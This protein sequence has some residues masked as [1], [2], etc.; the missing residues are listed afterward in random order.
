MS[1]PAISFADLSN[2]FM[3]TGHIIHET[4]LNL[5]TFVDKKSNTFAVFDLKHNLCTVYNRPGRA[6]QFATKDFDYA[7]D[8]YKP[9]VY[10]IKELNDCNNSMEPD[11]RLEEKGHTHPN[12]YQIPALEGLTNWV[13]LECGDAVRYYIHCDNNLYGSRAAY[14]SKSARVRIKD[15]QWKTVGGRSS[16]YGL[17]IDNLL[18][19]DEELIKLGFIKK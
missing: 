19:C 13:L 17:S 6:Y 1:I 11:T 18:A 3:Q 8:K 16:D 2:C 15:N 7:L 12:N 9:H 10:T 5:Y 14:V 4:D